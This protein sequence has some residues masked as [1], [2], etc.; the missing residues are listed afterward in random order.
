MSIADYGSLSNQKR[1]EQR[2][3]NQH[4]ILSFLAQ[5]R[6]VTIDSLSRLFDFSANQKSIY[7]L[8]T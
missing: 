2:Q 7:Y 4:K 8:R 6:S 1:L 3:F 5:E